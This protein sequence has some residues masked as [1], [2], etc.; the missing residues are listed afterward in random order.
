MSERRR[1]VVLGALAFVTI[2]LVITG[3]VVRR[4][5]DARLWEHAVVAPDD[6]CAAP[7]R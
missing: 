1:L 2:S 4:S 5:T 7:G 6:G 3:V